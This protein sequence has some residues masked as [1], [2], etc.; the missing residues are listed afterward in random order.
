M[1]NANWS[2]SSQEGWRLVAQQS[3]TLN[4]LHAPPLRRPVHL[5]YPPGALAAPRPFS[6]IV[7]PSCC[8]CTAPYEQSTLFVCKSNALASQSFSR[9]FVALM[10]PSSASCTTPREQSI[11]FVCKNNAFAGPSSA[12]ITCSGGVTRP[13]WGESGVAGGWGEVHGGLGSRGGLAPPAVVP[14]F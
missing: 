5:L 10:A 3:T 2:T 8:S 14:S 9:P 4:F 6:A 7:A 12:L 11:L 1:S 13:R